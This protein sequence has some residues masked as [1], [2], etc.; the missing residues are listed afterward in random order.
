MSFGRN[1]EAA[2][3][4]KNW[5]QDDLS[6]KTGISRNVIGK[7]ERNENSPSV[8]TA[9]KLAD[10]L[11]VSLDFLAETGAASKNPNNRYAGIIAKLEALTQSE[12]DHVSAI[13]DTFITKTTK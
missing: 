11:E 5:T 9:A 2:R 4:R 10:A 13:V 7:Y 8:D 6:E 12:V 3:K 1:L